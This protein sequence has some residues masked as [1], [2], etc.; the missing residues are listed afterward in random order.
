[1]YFTHRNVDDYFKK[2]L[3]E[4]AKADTRTPNSRKTNFQGPVIFT[5]AKG[6]FPCPWASLIWEAN[7]F[8]VTWSEL[9]RSLRYGDYGYG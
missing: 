9:V 6:P 3:R 8:R 4:K 2:N 5:I 1:M 7:A